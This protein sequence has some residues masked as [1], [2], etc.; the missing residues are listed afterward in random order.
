MRFLPRFLPRF[1]TRSTHLAAAT[2]IEA[3]PAVFSR[4]E[5]PR[6]LVDDVTNGRQVIETLEADLLRAI[7]A[8]DERARVAGDQA[9]A[10]R[11]V[12]TRIHEQMA[13]LTHAGRGAATGTVSL[14]DA[15]E[16]LTIAAH[17]IT[18]SVGQASRQIDGAALTARE[19]GDLVAELA[20]ATREIGGIVA[21]ISDVARQTNLL[22]LNAT[23]E[24]ARAG[25]AGRGFA[26][27]ANEVKALAVQTT[28]ATADIRTRIERLNQSA[29][30]SIAAARRIAAIVGE[31]QPIFQLLAGAITNQNQSISHIAQSATEASG[32]VA[33]VSNQA[34]AADRAAQDAAAGSL[35]AQEAVAAVTQV[36]S[37]LS[38]RFVAVLR[39]T[40]LGDR[41]RH[42]RYPV[43]MPVR[44][45]GRSGPFA[46][47]TVDIG[48][49]GLLL[50]RPQDGAS[51][52]TI[53]GT[54]TADVGTLGR[55]D[56]R[57]V[58]ESP[59]GWHCAFAGETPQ[60]AAAVTAIAAGYEPLIAR[61]REASARIVAR[62]EEGL[63]QGRI[64]EEALFST[65]YRLI[66]GTDPAQFEAPNLHFLESILPDIQEAYMAADERVVFACCVDRNAYLPVH[67]R[68]YSKP[69]R[70]GDPVWNAANSRNRR[71]FDDRAGIIAGRST[72][73]FVIQSYLRDMGGGVM[74]MRREVDVPLRVAG[75][76]W[77]GF[78]AAYSL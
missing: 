21:T 14:A 74:V 40:E 1:L 77:G 73:P 15:T 18:H 57:L 8:V 71:I 60:V 13:E 50:A 5:G 28:A 48:I 20:V 35:M 25:A 72:R 47:S 64:T 69:Q 45:Q 4:P 31:I 56:L 38:R 27:V 61:A 49:G 11:D 67:N 58:G 53:G 22:A 41:R 76:H 17:E 52:A 65:D 23:I 12:L 37:G 78:R 70:P 32:F 26:V 30:N 55:L 6:A 19:T 54:F 63:S 43:E 59:L 44:G 7:A 66:P 16:E 2:Q 29:E 33:Q 68:I 3:V 24:A 42:D 51:P 34:E 10:M 39:Q 75:R 62:M 9:Q 46:T 36:T